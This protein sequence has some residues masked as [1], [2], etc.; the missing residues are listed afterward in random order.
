MRIEQTSLP[1]VL[2][3]EPR[4]FSDDRGFFL[5]AFNE[6]R[7]AQH[8]LPG[9]FCQD[10]HS[11]SYRGVLRGLHYQLHHPQGKLVTVIQGRVFDVAV[12]IRRGSSTFGQWHGVTLSGEQPRYLWI[13]PGFA[14]GF[15]AL[16]EVADIVYKCTAP[17]M[18]GDEGGILWNDPV[19]GIDW[20]LTK[21]L[22][23]PKDQHYMPLDSG[24]SD[25]PVLQPVTASW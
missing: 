10:N 4:I 1:G 22:L 23:S 15:C 14:H 5:E 21:P 7:F 19:L 11:R 3:V 18:P 24:R 8:G 25:L 9:H 20:P 13:P 2:I 6:E 16:S 17:Y 12:D